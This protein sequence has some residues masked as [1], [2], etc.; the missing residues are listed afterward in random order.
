MLLAEASGGEANSSSMGF[1]ELTQ[2]SD[3]RKAC[4]VIEQD[5]SYT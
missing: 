4:G 2:R 5:W 3:S 1:G